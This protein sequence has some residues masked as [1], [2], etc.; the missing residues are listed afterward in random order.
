MAISEKILRAA[1]ERSGGRCECRNERHGYG[2]R[3]SHSLL[4]NMRGAESAVGAWS[5]VRRTT[6][7]TDVLANMELLLCGVS[8]ASAAGA[9]PLKTRSVRA[10][11]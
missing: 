4:W 6:W 9:R 2:E 1:W 5:P 8:E 7:G 3:C 10:I 11:L